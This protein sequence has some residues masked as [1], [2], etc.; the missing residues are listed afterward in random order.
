MF[1][2]PTRQVSLMV[3]VMFV[4]HTCNGCRAV[5]SRWEC[6]VDPAGLYGPE[7]LCPRCG[8]L[9]QARLTLVGWAVTLSAAVALSIAIV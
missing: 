4:I 8:A 7:R 3:G 6:V 9:V 2:E 5:L 1:S